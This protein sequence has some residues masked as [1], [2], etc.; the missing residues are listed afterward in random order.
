MA[1]RIVLV[2]ALEASIEPIRQ[3]FRAGWPQAETV[4]LLDDSLS[5]DRAADRTLTPAMIERFVQL[6]RYAVAI[7]ADGILFTCSAFHRAIDVARE[8]L[9]LPVLK[10]DEAMM[11]AALDCG[12]RI[13]LLATFEPTL[14]TA[15]AELRAMAAARGR[16]V[17]VRAVHV[18]AALAALQSGD[19]ET[20][21]RLIAEKA[22]Q[23]GTC[24][25]LLLAQFSMAPTAAG[26]SPPAGARLLTSPDTAVAKMRR[27]LEG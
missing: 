20:H 4:N 21:A 2:H 13:T 15:A 16:E 19:A 12:D 1:R 14:A 9:D 18:P 11:E 7:G 10:P 3:A 25:A 27:V 8:G 26:V 22:A 17:S 24:D 23:Q 5:V 6:T